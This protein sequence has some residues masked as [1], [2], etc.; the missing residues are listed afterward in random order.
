MRVV[1]PSDFDAEGGEASGHGV[2]GLGE[3]GRQLL[4]QR[5]VFRACRAALKQQRSELHAEGGGGVGL[6]AGGTDPECFCGER[7]GLVGVSAKLRPQGPR[8]GR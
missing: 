3:L 6:A 2:L 1:D 5:D 8:V 4:E 7:L